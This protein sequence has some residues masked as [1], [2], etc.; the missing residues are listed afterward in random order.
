MTF[1]VKLSQLKGIGDAPFAELVQRHIEALTAHRD[2][3][4]TKEQKAGPPSPTA[5]PFVEKAVSRVRQPKGP[6]QFVADYEVIDDTHPPP[7]P[8]ELKKQAINESRAK[9]YA[10]IAALMPES[11]MRLMQMDSGRA[12]RVP[13]YERTPEQ[14]K[15]I[16]AWNK[17]QDD[18]ER[19]QYESAKREADIEGGTP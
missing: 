17:L 13:E 3:P 1:K 16:E 14:T 12:L 15:A 8:E 18:I 6:D 19:I 10:D 5:H 4:L 11:R 2:T 9:E 7:N